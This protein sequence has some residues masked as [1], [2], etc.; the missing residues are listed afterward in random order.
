MNIEQVPGSSC[1]VCGILAGS[2]ERVWPQ[3][4]PLVTEALEHSRG[5]LWPEDVFECLV[6]QFMQLWIAYREDGTL[7]ACMVTQIIHYP[8]KKFLRVVVLSGDEMS[9]WEHGWSFVETWARAQGCTGVEAYARKGFVRRAKAQGFMEYY[10]MIGK[11][12][13]ALNVH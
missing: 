1:K 13:P 2:V 7:R 9:E 8:R 12:L 10:S 6:E 11:D 4:A 3:V 5:E